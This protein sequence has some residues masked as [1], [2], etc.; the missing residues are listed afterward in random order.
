M[1]PVPG[2]DRHLG[3]GNL[4]VEPTLDTVEQLGVD[5]GAGEQGDEFATGPEEAL[6][7]LYSDGGQVVPDQHDVTVDDAEG[8]AGSAVPT[9]SQR[10]LDGNR[11]GAVPG[12]PRRPRHRDDV[13]LDGGGRVEHGHRGQALHRG[14]EGMT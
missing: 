4:V 14:A 8:V 7:H 12:R 1:P 5:V 10:L 6:E 11:H 9:R 13:V 3:V 2:Q